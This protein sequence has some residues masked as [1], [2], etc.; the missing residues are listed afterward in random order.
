VLVGVTTNRERI[1]R[2]ASLWPQWPR[3]SIVARSGRLLY[4]QI[5]GAENLAAS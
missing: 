3:S 2:V 5:V 1:H 4:Y